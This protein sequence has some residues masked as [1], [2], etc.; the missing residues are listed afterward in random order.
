MP[1]STLPEV[2][3]FFFFSLL[4]FCGNNYGNQIV[5]LF[6][7]LRDYVKANQLI[8]SHGNLNFQ[9]EMSLVSD[10]IR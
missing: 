7:S 9:K 1:L 2:D 10:D 8:F 3:N 4:L 5:F 6:S